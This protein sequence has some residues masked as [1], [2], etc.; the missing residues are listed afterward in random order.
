VRAGSQGEVRLHLVCA[1]GY[2]PLMWWSEVGLVKELERLLLENGGASTCSIE[3]FF[4]ED[5]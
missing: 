2:N 3:D 1:H 5:E 4:D